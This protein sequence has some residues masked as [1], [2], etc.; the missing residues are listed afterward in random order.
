MRTQTIL[1]KNQKAI[2]VFP[3]DRAHLAKV[4]TALRLDGSYSVIVLIGGDINPQQNAVTQI[5]LQTIAK[6]ADNLHGVLISGGTNMGIMADI[7]QIHQ[8]NHYKFRLLGILPEALVTWPGGPRS[9]KFLWWGQQRWQLENHYSHFLLVP[10]NQFGDESPWIVDFA[11]L[12]SKSR[13][14]VT[15]LING[16]ESSRKDIQLSLS[17]GRSTIVLSQTGRLADEIAQNPNRDKSITVI[18]A[19]SGKQI[20]QALRTALSPNDKS[21]ADQSIFTTNLVPIE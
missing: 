2:C 8:K 15:V 1:F 9:T 18:P 12:L 5:A 19:S 6:T 13:K 11:T 20:S 10:G 16:G 17:I 3:D 21:T 4:A 14:A 7:G